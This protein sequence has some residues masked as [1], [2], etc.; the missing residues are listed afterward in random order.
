MGKRH[1][2]AIHKENNYKKKITN[3]QTKPNH[4]KILIYFH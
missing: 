3:D 4:E 1:E 2:Q